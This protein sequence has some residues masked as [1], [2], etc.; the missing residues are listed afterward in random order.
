MDQKPK[1]KDHKIN[2]K[3]LFHKSKT[4]HAKFVE[5]NESIEHEIDIE[6]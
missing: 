3:K 4:K 2:F 5:V 6:E 1:Q